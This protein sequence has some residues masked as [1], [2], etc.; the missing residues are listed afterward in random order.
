MIYVV[1]LNG[2][3]LFTTENT[4][5]QTSII[6]PT[7][8]LALNDAGSF[9]ADIAPTHPLYD[10]VET[11]ADIDIYCDNQ[12]LW[13]GRIVEVESDFWKVKSI[14]CEGALAFL[15]DSIQ[16][17]HKYQYV[18][19][20]AYRQYL[21]AV[22]AEHNSQVEANRR[23]QVGVV[24]KLYTGT[25]FYRY[26]NYE[27]TLKE[28]KDDLIAD[29]GGYIRIRK[30][31]GVFYLDYIENYNT[32]QRQTI[33]FGENLLDFARNVT[34]GDIATRVIPLGASLEG[35]ESAEGLD[36]RLTIAAVNDGKVYLEA[37]AA[38]ERYGKITKVVTFDTINNESL[39]KSR[40]QQWLSDSQ[41]ESVVFDVSC[42]DLLSI[43]QYDYLVTSDDDTLL[44]SDGDRFAVRD[45]GY[46]RVGDSIHV[47]STPHGL[48][49]RFPLSEMTINIADPSTTVI[50]LG[51][52]ATQMSISGAQSKT[53]ESLNTLKEEK[54]PTQE[55]LEAAQ[56][57]AT[58]LINTQ[59]H[60]FVVLEPNRILI[61]DASTIEEA[62]NIWQWNSGGLGHSSDGGATYGD[63]AITMDGSIN[64]NFITAGQMSANYI[65]GGEIRDTTGV[66]YWNLATGEFHMASSSARVVRSV[67]TEYGKSDTAT[68]EPLN[69][70]TGTPDWEQGKFIW[71]RTTTTY[72][73]NTYVQN[74]VCIQ[75][76]RGLGTQILGT[77]Q[78]QQDLPAS[79]NP[80][81]V[82]LIDGNGWTWDATAN[83][84]VNVGRIQG[85]QGAT[86]ADGPQGVQGI[87]GRSGTRI[88]GTWTSSNPLPTTGNNDGDCWIVDGNGFVWD[89]LAN[90]PAW[91]NIGRLRGDNGTDGEDGQ[92]GDDGQDGVSVVS[93]YPVY[94]LHT[95]SV[96]EPADNMFSPA[97]PEWVEGKYIWTAQ[98]I[99]FS[100]GVITLSEKYCDTNL[101]TVNEKWKEV[102]DN[103][104]ELTRKYNEM[105]HDISF[106]WLMSS[107]TVQI[108]G[109]SVEGG[110]LK[111]S[112]GHYIDTTKAD[113][114]KIGEDITQKLSTQ[115]HQTAEQIE[116]TASETY[117][118]KTET[119]NAITTLSNHYDTVIDQTAE[120]LR[121]EA[122]LESDLDGDTF[123][124]TA[125]GIVIKPDKVTQLVSNAIT[126]DYSS[127][128]QTAYSLTNILNGFNS[129]ITNIVARNAEDDKLAM[130]FGLAVSWSTEENPVRLITTDER[131]VI[132][133]HG[134][135]FNR[136]KDLNGEIATAIQQLDDRITLVA[137]NESD[138]IAA[139]QVYADRINMTVSDAN[140]RITRVEQRA[141]GIYAD[142]NRSN[143]FSWTADGLKINVSA[144]DLTFGD[145]VDGIDGSTHSGHFSWT[146]ENGLQI[147]MGA[148]SGL[149]WDTNGN[150]KV[151]LS[152]LNLTFGDIKTSSSDN[153]TLTQALSGINTTLNG[154]QNSLTFPDGSP[155][156]LTNGTQLNLNQGGLSLSVGQVTGA[157]SKD[158]FDT[159]SANS[160]FKWSATTSK[161]T[162]DQTK[163]NLSV[164]Q[165]AQLQ[166]TL[167]G[168]QGNLSVN[169]T[170]GLLKL[171]TNTLEID[172]SKIQLSAQTKY[173][174]SQ[175]HTST[176]GSSFEIT[177][178]NIRMAWNGI[179]DYI[180][181]E[182]SQSTA[183]LL[184]KG[185]DNN[186]LARLSR[187]G[188][189]F[190][191]RDGQTAGTAT[192]KADGL[193]FTN[194]QQTVATLGVKGSVFYAMGSNASYKSL[195]INSSGATFYNPD[196]NVSGS[197]RILK[198]DGNGM[199]VYR[200]TTSNN[201][202]VMNINGS[203][204]MSV[205]YSGTTNKMATFG[206]SGL[207][208]YRSDGTTMMTIQ[209]VDYN[210]SNTSQNKLKYITFAA[211]TGIV[212]SD[213]TSNSKLSFIG[214]ELLLQ[215][216]QSGGFF[217]TP[218]V[219]FSANAVGTTSRGH[220]Y[221]SY[222][223][224]A[225]IPRLT[226]VY[227][228][229]NQGGT[230]LY[231][232][233]Y[234]EQ[235]LR[236]GK[237]TADSQGQVSW[238]GT[239]NL[240]VNGSIWSA[241]GATI[242][243]S[244]SAS[245][246]TSSN[247]LT[248]SSGGLT[249]TGS[250]TL[251]NGLTVSSGGLTVTGDSTLYN[252]LTVNGSLSAGSLSVSGSMSFNS[253]DVNAVTCPT[254]YLH[255][256]SDPNAEPSL[257]IYYTDRTISISG[258]K[259]DAG[260]DPSTG[261]TRYNDSYFIDFHQYPDSGYNIHVAPPTKFYRTLVCDSTLYGKFIE[262]ET[263][264]LSNIATIN[265]N[266]T[267]RGTIY[268]TL[269]G[270]GSDARLKKNISPSTVKAL[271]A[272]TALDIKSYDWVKNDKHVKAGIIAQQLQK[273][274]PD[275]IL[276]HGEE[277]ELSINI[278]Q[279]LNYCVKAIQ[280]LADMVGYKPKKHAEWTDPY[281]LEEKLA[282]N[283]LHSHK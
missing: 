87:Q 201:Y 56:R 16:P 243:G 57:N 273:V 1:E 58:E 49:A 241:S 227:I 240:E 4:N 151:K 25:S 92:R 101:N 152:S 222:L 70:S 255:K 73:D 260:R 111:T 219:E 259:L 157:L 224:D 252:N 13:S 47:I 211:D 221:T 59:T 247:G 11:M 81:D 153:T 43:E 93:I 197:P 161:F 14:Y 251:N 162:I 278:E 203:D 6:N 267:V 46:F 183:R 147:N 146:E 9:T 117:T 213:E 125:A 23:F 68:D 119:E 98:R 264:S 142:I 268:G 100:S 121:L 258:A 34:A 277:K 210:E 249:V 104:E 215:K 17:P 123:E 199:T 82:W 230:K 15:N 32:A 233:V 97:I 12:W 107:E 275:L 21:E 135:I 175:G 231:G 155:L 256:F 75:G 148:Q 228:K 220:S 189:R 248:V 138:D 42:I 217:N 235:L 190:V 174:D 237:K 40:G 223:I 31:D 236:V 195:E 164:S 145:I 200:G 118:K 165:V 198:I 206:S 74:A 262:G 196:S 131:L 193:I 166:D 63:A 3:V 191:L 60:G 185:S 269:A 208:F 239:G 192:F 160:P 83:D 137:R 179:S 207:S 143:Q 39:L 172:Q 181:F 279:L 62:T 24:E 282:Y 67:L 79:G 127:Q 205:Y 253:L 61:M 216:L 26:T 44:T 130:R 102:T 168:K 36:A 169:D 212:F 51:V 54:I 37:P 229:P 188:L 180:Q 76:A 149:Q 156:S 41:W 139:I 128:E 141:D 112:D 194:T 94:A 77:K 178:E 280:E 136:L 80:G 242:G 176:I 7:L 78:S 274:A 283:E 85:P 170:T 270:G 108:D 154:K 99:E 209:N 218:S 27:S 69:W 110:R 72:S 124:K 238:T 113:A 133:F 64:A 140:N 20:T 109:S 276:E 187:D 38:V 261:Q 95:S 163:I 132:G 167:D 150:L 10:D 129:S 254:W 265:S 126:Q 271:E 19:G 226:A 86:G 177:A 66:N 182:G 120:Q 266:L 244:L 29:A 45:G 204:G 245:G 105:R 122:V 250:S 246:V 103:D 33:S 22:I 5:P 90:P 91:V 234:V 281:T 144:L 257:R 186:E 53:S 50:T 115:I 158:N 232:A 202:A 48:N 159:T 225:Y 88:V 272:L 263:L 114:V 171:S 106:S 2:Q 214:G 96:I 89:A 55:I 8:K 52:E 30:D 35:Q 71:A 173:V 184:F 134:D 18:G 65:Y 116:Q 84:W 28:I